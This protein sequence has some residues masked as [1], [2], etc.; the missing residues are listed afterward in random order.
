M[1]EDFFFLE[2]KYL[3]QCINLYKE[4]LSGDGVITLSVKDAFYFN[5][6]QLLYMNK[7][8]TFLNERKSILDVWFYLKSPY[9]Y[10]YTPSKRFLTF[11]KKNNTIIYKGLSLDIESERNKQDLFSHNDYLFMNN[12]Y[13]K[14]A[15]DI[16][17]VNLINLMSLR[18]NSCKQF[19]KKLNFKSQEV[20]LTLCDL[21]IN[22]KYNNNLLLF[23]SRMPSKRDVDA[24]I[25]QI[26]PLIENSTMHLIM[27]SGAYEQ[28][29]EN[30]VFVDGKLFLIYLAIEFGSKISLKKILKD[31][32]YLSLIKNNGVYDEVMTS[33][34][35][36][37]EIKQVF[38]NALAKGITN[39][40]N[41]FSDTR[42]IKRKLKI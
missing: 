21:L 31:N 18:G 29:K 34:D 27:G 8:S 13:E 17:K 12:F 36:S 10:S 5:K 26:K 7:V 33:K 22:Q 42:E 11:C 4:S 1:A 6:E 16:C 24:F 32:D 40:L 30:E 37:G 14:H 3:K 20:G 39:S 41:K 25:L 38:A 9:N 23:V 35:F 19:Y 2:D 15:I 28:S